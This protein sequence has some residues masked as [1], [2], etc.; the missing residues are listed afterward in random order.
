MVAA[1]LAPTLEG[2][3]VKYAALGQT[4]FVKALF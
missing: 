3:E 4:V 2:F 1:D